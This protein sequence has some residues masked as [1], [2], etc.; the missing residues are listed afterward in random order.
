M[1]CEEF[2]EKVVGLFDKNVDEKTKSECE[3]HVSQCPDCKKY[4]EELRS[5]F[6]EVS[7]KVEP[8]GRIKKTQTDDN[9]SLQTDNRNGGDVHTRSYY[10]R[11]ASVLKYCQG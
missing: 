9:Q 5:A 8:V 2:K 7:P 4:Y 3:H 11:D 6:G 10:R 1:N